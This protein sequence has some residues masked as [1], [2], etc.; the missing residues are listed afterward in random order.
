MLNQVVRVTKSFSFDMAHALYGYDG[1]CKNIHGHTYRLYVTVAGYPLADDHHPKNGMVI[2][3]SDL[4]KIVR[5]NIIDSF[6]H[7]LVLYEKSPHKNLQPQLTQQFEK[8]IFLDHQPTCEN[9][10]LHF[11][12]I[13][14]PHYQSHIKLVAMRL[15]ETPDSYSEWLRNDNV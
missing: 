11:Q 1:P 5:Q 3:F 2:D 7:A 9:L 12:R 8:I 14:L 13:L 15:E 6:D 4:K 10:L